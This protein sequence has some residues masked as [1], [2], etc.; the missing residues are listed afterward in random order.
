MARPSGPSSLNHASP[1]S[2]PNIL[3]HLPR[4]DNATA[5]Y[6][7]PRSVSQGYSAAYLGGPKQSPP[8]VQ[9]ARGSDDVLQSTSFSPNKRRRSDSNAT[10]MNVIVPQGFAIAYPTSDHS[11]SMYSN[12]LPLS[13]EL[14]NCGKREDTS[15][16][17]AWETKTDLH[18]SDDRPS[19]NTSDTASKT[20]PGSYFW[21]PERQVPASGPPFKHYYQ[22]RMKVVI[23]AHKVFQTMQTVL[24]GKKDSDHGKIYTLR[25]AERPGFVKIGRTKNTI[26]ERKAQINRCIKYKLEVI[27][28]DDHCPVQNHTR[29]EKLIHDELRNYRQSFLCD[30]K[31]NKAHGDANDGLTTHGEWFRIDE[32][33]AVEVVTRWRKWM[34][35]KPYQDGSLIQ[36]EKRRINLYDKNPDH[37]K[38]MVIGNDE[39]WSWDVF[40][41]DTLWQSC[42]LWVYANFFV[43]R[44]ERPTCSSW[45]SLWKHWKSNVIFGLGFFFISCFLSVLS[46]FF[47]LSFAFAPSAAVLHTLVL[48]SGAILYAA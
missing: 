19:S 48:G 29:V 3:Q 26:D 5:A 10:Q 43:E 37:M 41:E 12:S 2:A 46:D 23:V 9:H 47:Q 1:V 42:K 28:D 31:H 33:K 14:S 36:K 34:E 7:T 32:L 17:Y 22:D 44:Y 24:S 39:D 40:M 25:L 38:A 8:S 27:N 45:D 15:N 13:R 6:G 18:D 30:C 16:E 20:F 35:A 4:K 21:G 11:H